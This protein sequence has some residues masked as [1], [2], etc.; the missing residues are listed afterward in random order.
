[1]SAA[2]VK[3]NIAVIDLLRYKDTAVSE[4]V[5]GWFVVGDGLDAFP[6][7]LG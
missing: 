6:H 1:M 7:I 5:W 4:S 2:L 3:T